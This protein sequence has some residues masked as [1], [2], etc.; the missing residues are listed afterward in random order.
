MHKY[1]VPDTQTINIT[2]NDIEEENIMNKKI[3]TE[4]IVNENDSDE[5][6]LVDYEEDAENI[7]YIKQK[8]LSTNTSP[9]VHSN[10][11]N[12]GCDDDDD[13]VL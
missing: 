2:S 1:D 9:L 10:D 5:N 7:E 4:N 13:D 11:N 3:R 8:S 12:F 6:S